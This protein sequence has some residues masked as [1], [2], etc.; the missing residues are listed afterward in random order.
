MQFTTI[1]GMFAMGLI[2][3][4]FDENYVKHATLLQMKKDGVL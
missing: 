2:K 3:G 1:K 4:E